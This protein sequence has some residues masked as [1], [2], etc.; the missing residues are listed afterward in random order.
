MQLNSH[1][2]HPLHKQQLPTGNLK[3][4]ARACQMLRLYPRKSPSARG[5][6]A[7]P[8][9][10]LWLGEQQALLP[11]HGSS[12]DFNDLVKS[13][14]LQ[15][16]ASGSAAPPAPGADVSPLPSPAFLSSRACSFLVFRNSHPRSGN[17]LPSFTSSFTGRCQHVPPVPPSWGHCTLQKAKPLPKEGQDYILPPEQG[18]SSV[19][20]C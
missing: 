15:I 2:K 12:Q 7:G 18:G 5:S 13:L 11:Q 8:F 1:I 14:T 19:S 4:H 10:S 9:P 6:R 3:F 16:T 17:L 20:L